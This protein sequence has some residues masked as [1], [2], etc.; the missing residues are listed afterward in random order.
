MA[1]DRRTRFL[2]RIAVGG[3][4]R[5]SDDLRAEL[6][7]ALA[8]GVAPS[9]CYEVVMQNYLFAGFPAALEGLRVF[10]EVLAERDIDFRPP[11]AEPYDVAAF[12]SRGRP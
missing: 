1:L 7:A 10:H 6:G 3:A 8:G 4:L 2:C 9:E 11:E 12:R 5:R